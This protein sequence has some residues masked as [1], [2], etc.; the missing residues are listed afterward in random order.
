MRVRHRHPS[1]GF[2]KSWKPYPSWPWTLEDGLC[3]QTNTS[4]HR[5][6]PRRWRVGETAELDDGAD[7]RIDLRRTPRFDVLKHRRLV[8]ADLFRA[9]DPPVDSDA[10]R[11]AELPRDH[12]GLT[13]HVGT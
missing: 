2:P 5:I 4:V 11:D 8:R 6:D 3:E 9:G 1:S 12:L 13:H 7:Q 10:E